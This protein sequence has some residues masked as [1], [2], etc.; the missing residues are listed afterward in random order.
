MIPSELLNGTRV[1]TPGGPGSVAYIRLN[2]YDRHSVDAVSVVLDSRR[3]EPGY[4]G[5][6]Y[7][8]TDVELGK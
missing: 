3:A 4:V 6:I 2:A 7:R 8:V 1:T 5:T